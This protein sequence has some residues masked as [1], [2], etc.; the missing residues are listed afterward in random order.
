MY[1]NGGRQDDFYDNEEGKTVQLNL[2]GQIWVNLYNYLET[3]NDWQILIAS[4]ATKIKETEYNGKACY[5]INDFMKF[6]Y[7][8][9]REMHIIITRR[10]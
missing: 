1:D 4:V 10:E 6:I 5:V 7:Q 2:E 3:D 9:I 8:L